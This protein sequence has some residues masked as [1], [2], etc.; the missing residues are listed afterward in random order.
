VPEAPA[1]ALKWCLRNRAARPRLLGSH[2]PGR[3]GAPRAANHPNPAR[4]EPSPSG[5]GGAIHTW[6]SGLLS[7]EQ[8]LSNSAQSVSS[9]SQNLL[10][11]AQRSPPEG[12]SAHQLAGCRPQ[13]SAC[14]HSSGKVAYHGA[15]TPSRPGL[16]GTAPMPPVSGNRSSSGSRSLYPRRHPWLP[17]YIAY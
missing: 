17:S 10:P 3:G 11:S 13:L 14:E 16:P 12:L 1:T 6:Q 2:K 7:C 5:A 8:L 15:E 9:S 4:Q